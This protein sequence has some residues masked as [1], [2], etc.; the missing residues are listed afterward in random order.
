MQHRMKEFSMA[1]EATLALL[2]RGQVGVISTSGADGAPYGV[3]VHY[4]WQDGKL[5]F[6]G[7]PAGEKLENIA[8]DH[9]VCFTVWEFG[10]ILTEGAENPCQADAAYEC[11]VLR[12]KARLVDDPAQKRPHLPGDHRKVC[13]GASGSAHSR[14]PHRRYSPGGSHPCHPHRQVSPLMVSCSRPAP[15]SRSRAVFR[16]PGRKRLPSP[17]G[18][19]IMGFVNPVPERVPSGEGNFLPQGRIFMPWPG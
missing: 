1:P 14:G 8:R 15:Y 11:A 10:G 7:L 17:A 13:S 18:T 2:G 4:L 12:G 3:P 5:W 16:S 19:I 9:R 6:H